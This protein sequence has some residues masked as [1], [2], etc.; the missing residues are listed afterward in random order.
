MVKGFLEKLALD[1][2][3]YRKR[4]SL[5]PGRS[6]SVTL[7]VEEADTAIALG[8]GDVPVLATPR[9]IALAEEASIEAVADE[10]AP[11]TTSV[12]YEVQLAHL[13]PTAVGSKVTAE[14]TL[15]SVEG[16]RLTFRVSVTDARGLVAAGR[17]T[18][19]VVVR[20]RFI[21]RSQSEI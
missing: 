19:V 4:M 6:A 3:A 2:L 10:L 12:G 18:R 1:H 8:S 15:E 20:D 17:I 16:R 9:V 14:A 11:G 5:G 7:V 13:A 21:E